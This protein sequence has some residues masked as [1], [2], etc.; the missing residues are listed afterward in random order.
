MWTDLYVRQ[1]IYQSICRERRMDT[2]SPKKEE[3]K[4]PLAGQITGALMEQYHLKV[5][6]L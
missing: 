3:K 6:N 1:S 4:G 2:L 5:F